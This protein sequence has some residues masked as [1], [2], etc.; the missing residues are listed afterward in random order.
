MEYLHF[1]SQSG[2]KGCQNWAIPSVPFPGF[3]NSVGRRAGG[4]A[5]LPGVSPGARNL[6]GGSQVLPGV[7]RAL[8]PILQMRK[9][10]Q[11][12]SQAAAGLWLR[13]AVAP[14]SPGGGEALHHLLD[15][16]LARVG[17]C[18][19]WRESGL[20]KLPSHAVTWV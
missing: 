19:L 1:H 8:W 12:L 13:S 11:G 16:A 5:S 17:G 9:Q 10:A 7:A 15:R 2:G 14:E 18:W 20:T 4:D 6:I 3:G